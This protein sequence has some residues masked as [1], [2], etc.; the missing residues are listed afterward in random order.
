MPTSAQPV[1]VRVTMFHSGS[2]VEIAHRNQH[3][4][5]GFSKANDLHDVVF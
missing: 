3:R 2:H 1:D 4:I 5:I